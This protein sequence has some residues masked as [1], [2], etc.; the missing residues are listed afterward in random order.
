MTTSAIHGGVAGYDP[1]LLKGGEDPVQAE[2]ETAA[3]PTAER[4]SPVA[5]S[6]ASEVDRSGLDTPASDPRYT[7]T[8]GRRA[9]GAP[10][11]AVGRQLDVTG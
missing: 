10:V 3:V 5:Q 4:Y 8:Y 7:I 9:L 11:E 6:E 1:S 2:R